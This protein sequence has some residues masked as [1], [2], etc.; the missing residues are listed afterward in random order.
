MGIDE[1]T[2]F[3]KYNNLVTEGK[4]KPLSCPDCQVRLVTRV[5]DDQLYLYCCG[6]DTKI[7]PGLDVLDQ[8][9]AVVKEH[10]I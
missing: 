3:H 6:C 7:W 5:S 2:W 10:A 8:I 1:I 9:R 4:T